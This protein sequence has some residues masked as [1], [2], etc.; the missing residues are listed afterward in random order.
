MEGD[1]WRVAIVAKALE[2]GNL[3]EIDVVGLSQLVDLSI[4]SHS[5]GRELL[6]N[7]CLDSGFKL[8]GGGLEVPHVYVVHG[9]A[10]HLLLEHLLSEM[11]EI[12]HVVVAHL[13]KVVSKSL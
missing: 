4:E 2:E 11:T 10:A 13:V 3:L 1:E 9:P 7:D 12:F 8:R 6:V 5:H